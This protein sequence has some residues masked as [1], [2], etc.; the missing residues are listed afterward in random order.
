MA[1][2]RGILT[3]LILL[4]AVCGGLLGCSRSP[5][6]PQISGVMTGPG[7]GL[8]GAAGG[9][10]SVTGVIT[11][12]FP[13]DRPTVL[14]GAIES[15]ATD[16][17]IDSWSIPWV[18]LDRTGT[19][20]RF[21]SGNGSAGNSLKEGES[22]LVEVRLDLGDENSSVEGYQAKPLHWAV[23]CSSAPATVRYFK[24]GDEL[25]DLGQGTLLVLDRDA[26]G[27][28]VITQRVWKGQFESSLS[29]K[30]TSLN[31]VPVEKRA[32]GIADSILQELGY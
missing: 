22:R 24:I 17:A 31:Y 11:V 19:A 14:F 1:T 4:V 10:F 26:E 8:S 25:I 12:I 5:F 3:I 20:N 29:G 30:A 13:T 18:L 21:S 15:G 6:A 32:Q 2:G 16:Q 7:I 23:D 28:M 9:Y 27:E